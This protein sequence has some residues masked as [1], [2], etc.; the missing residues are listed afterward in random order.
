MSE[1][2]RQIIIPPH[3]QPG[4]IIGLV[5]P[6]GPVHDRDAVR[7]GINILEEAGFLVKL[8]DDLEKEAYLAGSDEARA[9]QLSKVWHDAEVKAILAVYE[10]C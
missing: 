5:T 4:D 3:L 1:T 2:A 6:A 10:S 8:P 9:H 7:A